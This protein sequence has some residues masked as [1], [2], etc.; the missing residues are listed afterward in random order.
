ME[1]FNS[2]SALCYDLDEDKIRK[3]PH[4]MQQPSL[5]AITKDTSYK[6]VSFK[7]QQDTQ[8]KDSQDTQD[9]QEQTQGS[10]SKEREDINKHLDKEEK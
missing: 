3:T 7:D 10:L 6:S 8:G 2:G 9:T 1:Y 5:S 4:S